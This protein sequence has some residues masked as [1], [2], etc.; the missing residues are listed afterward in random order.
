MDEAHLGKRREG[1]TAALLRSESF[2]TIHIV[3]ATPMIHSSKDLITFL[4]IIW[5][6]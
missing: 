6:C 5:V 4:D 1:N 3:T 2:D